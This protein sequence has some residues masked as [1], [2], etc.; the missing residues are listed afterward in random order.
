MSVVKKC[1]KLLQLKQHFDKWLP[2]RE[3]ISY[4]KSWNNKLK[5]DEYGNL[6]LINPGTP[7]LN[8][9]MDTVQSEQC[10]KNLHTLRLKN[11]TISAKD[12]VIWGDDKC[13]IAIAMEVYEKLG[14]Q[15]SLLF[16]R[17][18]ETGCNWAREFCEKHPDLIKLCPYCLTL[19]RRGKWDIIGFGNQYCSK[20]FQEEI[21]RLTK[22]FG[23]KPEH[24]LCSDANK[25]SKLINCVNL[26]VGYYNPH[27]KTEYIKCDE[28]VNAYEAVLHIIANFQ[29][30]YPIRE[31]PKFE[32]K[33]QTYNSWKW[34]NRN[35]NTLFDA[36]DDDDEYDYYD[37]YHS[38]SYYNNK[39]KN[40]DLNKVFEFKNWQLVVK[41]NIFITNVLDDMDWTE[42]EVWT[43]DICEYV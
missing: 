3:V 15:V 22:N 25:I 11:W 5:S 40:K 42:L 12:A 28:L 14:N 7:L 24:W 37:R 35:R 9:H 17:Q 19:D 29:W 8:A 43:Y 30:E 31:A 36:E 39:N 33:L 13:W 38:A 16:T 1:F 41:K 27:Q 2:E 20:E 23:Y 21:H 32:Q 18:E 34:Y 10:V 26:S 4:L 6:F